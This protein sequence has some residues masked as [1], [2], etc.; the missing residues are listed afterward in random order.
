MPCSNVDRV[1]PQA[2][3]SVRLEIHLTEDQ[4]KKIEQV[5]KM[6]S[7]Q[8]PEQKNGEILEYLC[9]LVLA[10]G[11]KKLTNNFE[12][13]ADKNKLEVAT[14][15]FLLNQQKEKLVDKNNIKSHKQEK[16]KRGRHIPNAIRRFVLKRAQNKCEFVSKDGVPCKSDYQVELEHVVPFSCGGEHSIENLKCFCSKHNAFAASQLNIGFEKLI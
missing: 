11:Q 3:K 8:Y 14:Q 2:N 6:L 5:K 16:L 4:Y 15:S 1:K 7:H 10:K 12:V 13:E 9:D